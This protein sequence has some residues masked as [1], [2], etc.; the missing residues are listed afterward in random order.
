MNFDEQHSQ[1]VLVAGQTNFDEIGAAICDFLS[2]H[3]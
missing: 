3:R 1:F 2:R